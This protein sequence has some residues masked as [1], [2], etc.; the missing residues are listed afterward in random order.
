MPR[1]MI[2]RIVPESSTIKMFAMVFPCSAF[3]E[4]S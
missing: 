4:V 2:F 1:M 3:A